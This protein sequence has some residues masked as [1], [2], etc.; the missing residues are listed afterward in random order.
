MKRSILLLFIFGSLHANSQ[1]KIENLIQAE[2]DFAAY[3]VAHNTKTAFLKYLDSA[4]IVFENGKAVNGIETWN[5]R[6]V[7]P[8]I[9]NWEPLYAEISASGNLG[10]TTGPWTFQPRTIS[11]SVI[12][13]GQYATVWQ[14]DKQGNWKFIIDLGVNETPIPEMKEVESI[15]VNK[16]TTTPL[17]LKAMIKAEEAFTRQFNK[18]RVHAYELYLSKKTVLNRNRLLPATH[19]DDLERS[20]KDTPAELKF[21]VDHSGISTS[22]DL[23]Y[24]YGT[25]LNKDKREN[26]L[27]VW[28]KENQGWR[29]AMEVVRY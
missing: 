11:D 21:H 13:R 14:L 6:E 8:G 29:I 10:Y 26:Y 4:G 18:D 2:K 19:A 12:A 9:L 23:G 17:D 16:I 28:R 1:N 24:V 22:G 27:R 20:I 15:K 5:K 25:T 7:R 3:A